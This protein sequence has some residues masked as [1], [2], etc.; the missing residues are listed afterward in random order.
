MKIVRIIARLNVGGPARHVIWLTKDLQDSEFDSTLVAGSVPPG[1]EDM[2]YLAHES[3]IEPVYIEQ[4]SRELSANDLVSLFKLYH[5]LKKEEPDIVHTHTAKAGTVGR[6]AALLYRWFTWRT[7]IGKPRKVR[8]VH[9]FHGHIFHSY[10][11]R[12]RTRLFVFI[13]RLLARLA[14]DKIVVITAQQLFEINRSVGIGKPEQF[15]AIK[16][17]IDLEPFGNAIGRSEL[18]EQYGVAHDELVVGIVGRLTE[19]KNI[20]LFLQAVEIYSRSEPETRP[21]LRFVI[22]GDGHLRE[23]LEN[24]ARERGVSEIVNFLGNFTDIAKLYSGLD[25]VALTSFNEGTPLSLIEAMASGRA[26]IATKVGGVI[27]LLGEVR[28]SADSFDIC[29]R[30]I[31]VESGSAAGLL[32]GLIYLANDPATRSK[33]ASAGSEFAIANYARERLS[34]DIR[35]LYRRIV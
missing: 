25:I 19:I 5:L 21:K 9:T 23:G 28:S 32:N 18:R 33:L 4:M 27:D 22:V 26:V 11:G 30:G 12:L 7:L 1:E 31:G 35:S 17:G 34:D 2:S 13:E 29:E 10:Y 16:L 14:T 15:E 6:S 8:I 20:S 3:G 24:E